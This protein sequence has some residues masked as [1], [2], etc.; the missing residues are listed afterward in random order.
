MEQPKPFSD[1]DLAE[2]T[3][4]DWIEEREKWNE[5]K[6]ADGS[7]LKVK[8]V[9]KGVKR[10]QKHTPDGTPIYMIGSE[11]IVRVTNVPKELKA[12]PRE[13]TFKPT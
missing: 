3:D 8:L 4:V 10:L 5:Y 12:K 1:Q 7:T 2:A 11:N 9:L 6:L 13:S